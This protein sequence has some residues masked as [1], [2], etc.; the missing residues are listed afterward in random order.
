MLSALQALFH[1]VLTTT[2][3]WISSF[4]SI[5]VN[6]IVDSLICSLLGYCL[7]NAYCVRGSV[8]GGPDT[9]C[10]LMKP[11]N[12]EAGAARPSGSSCLFS[13]ILFATASEPGS[14]RMRPHDL[15]RD[16]NLELRE[17]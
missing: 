11:I 7:L 6:S 13:S 10:D 1:S 5:S 9:A 16:W 17:K 2:Q 14:Q 3:T 4:L 15:C 8:L 12:K